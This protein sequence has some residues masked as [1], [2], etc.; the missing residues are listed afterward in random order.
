MDLEGVDVAF[1]YLALQQDGFTSTEI[2]ECEMLLVAS[3][4]YLSRRPALRHPRDL[5][6]NAHRCLVPNGPSPSTSP[7]VFTGPAGLISIRT[8][9]PF[10][11]EDGDVLT[12]WVL[13]GK[14]IANRPRFEVQHLVDE[15]AL[16]VVLTPFSLK[17]AS[18]FV[19]YRQ[20]GFYEPRL[21]KL[22]D[23]LVL[24]CR[25]QFNR[26]QTSGGAHHHSAVETAQF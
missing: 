8:S 14:G 4:E 9:S 23:N 7:W 12:D 18:L 6:G 17:S 13:E 16:A 24:H 15:G 19:A 11:V 3:P 10:H 5:N 21:S 25:R 2:A 1:R 20:R 22:V 26:P